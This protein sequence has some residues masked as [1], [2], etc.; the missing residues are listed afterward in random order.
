MD[1]DVTVGFELQ[2][3]ELNENGS[4]K[5]DWESASKYFKDN[6]TEEAYN[7]VFQT[8]TISSLQKKQENK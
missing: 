7:K 3:V 4:P 5:G 6:L 2:A 1:A 8:V